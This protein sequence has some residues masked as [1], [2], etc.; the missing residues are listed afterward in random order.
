MNAAALAAFLMTQAHELRTGTWNARV[1]AVESLPEAG[2]SALPLLSEAAHDA[3][4]QVRM[5]AVHQM[6][7]L[8]RPAL[9]ALETVL[10]EEPCRTVRLTALHWL[11]SMGPEA[12]DALRR[13]LSD[14]SG[15]VRLMGKYWLRKDGEGDAGEKWEAEAAARE[16]LKACVSSPMAGTAPW[17][18]GK[19]GAPDP[20][21]DPAAPVEQI[22]EVVVTRDPTIKR[23]SEPETMPPPPPGFG[24]RPAPETGVAAYSKTDRR[25]LKELDDIL[26]PSGGKAEVMPPAP[27][28]FG[29]RKPAA[30]AGADYAT[31]DGKGKKSEGDPLPVLIALLKD[32]D[33]ARRSRA[34]D[35]IG[36]RGAAAASAVPALS[37]ALQDRSPRVRAS[38]A[39]A[40]GNLG[41]AAD[42]A[43][44]ALIKALDRGPEEVS[45]SAAVALGRVGTPR[46]QKA[47]ARATKGKPVP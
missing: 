5:T 22:D 25:K 45:W 28:G 29:D 10:Q 16:S 8:G 14:D 2:V 38:A 21:G 24:E 20:A 32:G 35:D 13:A 41:K 26:G 23:S 4:W 44:P 3:D 17:A 36:K 47:F 7:R 34:A 37:A 9:P 27:A 6:G 42:A 18:R 30:T 11:G 40:L 33:P 46:A 1:H 43:V 15:M 39:L 19:K 12:S 31:D